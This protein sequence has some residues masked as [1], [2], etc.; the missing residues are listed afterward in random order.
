MEV[1][2][3]WKNGLFKFNKMD[4][5]SMMR[6]AERW[7]D[8]KVTYPNGVPADI[9]TGE[10]SREVNLSEFVKILQY[11]DVEAEISGKVLVVNPNQK[12]L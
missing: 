10:I 9:F 6:Q 12:T 2:M 5:K 4:I 7:Y 3:S 1:V 8:I 11:S